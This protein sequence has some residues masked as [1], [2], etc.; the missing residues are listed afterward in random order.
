MK[1]AKATKFHRKSGEGREIDPEENPSAIG[2]ALNRCVIKSIST[3]LRQVEG[4][5]IADSRPEPEQGGSCTCELCRT[6]YLA[7]RQ[8]GCPRV[9]GSGQRDHATVVTAPPP[10]V[11]VIVVVVGVGAAA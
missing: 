5:M 4:E 9:H 2:A 10:E 1:F 8:R 6:F 7:Y 11:T 3:C